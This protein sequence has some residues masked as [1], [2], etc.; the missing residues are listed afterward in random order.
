MRR[1]KANRTIVI[2]LII[3]GVILFWILAGLFVM[4]LAFGLEEIS[5]KW[6]IQNPYVNSHFTDWK[7]IS[8]YEFNTV[9]I[10]NDWSLADDDGDG[11]FSITDG[12]GNLWATG[13]MFGTEQDVF[14]DYSAFVASMTQKRPEDVTIELYD[15]F[16][17]MHASSIRV[18]TAQYPDE[19]NTYYFIE[20]YSSGKWFVFFLLSDVSQS[21]SDY[22]I[23]EAIIYSFVY[24]T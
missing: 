17:L 16:V 21:P 6:D 22:D 23:A 7:E 11:I 2:L 19:V 14:E 8:L 4:F 24:E 15:G 18:L 10:P 5:T 1:I 9:K 3:G 13:A 12:E 20:L